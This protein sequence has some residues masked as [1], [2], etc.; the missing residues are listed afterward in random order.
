[1]SMYTVSS[2]PSLAAFDCTD[3]RLRC[4]QLAGSRQDNLW[5][6]YAEYH[7]TRPFVL[8]CA[9][10]P[11]RFARTLHLRDFP[12]NIA[13][14]GASLGSKL[15]DLLVETMSCDECSGP[16]ELAPCAMTIRVIS[17]HNLYAIRDF[18]LSWTPF[19]QKCCQTRRLYAGSWQLA[20]LLNIPSL[21][22]AKVL[23]TVCA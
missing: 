19:C 8:A 3:V 9:N 5:S 20:R 4:E 18:L 23:K 6:D 13:F 21:R 11:I 7:C 22:Q 1:M 17:L 2:C 10:S 12:L 15:R 14:E 16:D